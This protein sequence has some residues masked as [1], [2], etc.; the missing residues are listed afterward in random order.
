MTNNQILDSVLGC[1]LYG[2]K[3][4][5]EGNSQYNKMTFEFIVKSQTN[6]GGFKI[7][8]WQM[9]FLKQTLLNDGFITL[10]KSGIE[11]YELTKEGIKA[12]Q[13]GWYK[14]NEK[15]IEIDE[16]IKS[17]TIENFK[18]SKKSL[19]VSILALIIPTVLSIYNLIQVSN[20]SK[21]QE[22]EKLK[23]EIIEIQSEL[24]IIHQKKV[25]ENK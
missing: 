21:D 25:T 6:G 15:N 5:L 14:K 18:H 24:K 20:N 10:P 7:D 1:Y 22:I 17:L 23:K 12:A 9:E 3:L 4:K 16:K 13:N 8:P 11:P 2:Q 19:I